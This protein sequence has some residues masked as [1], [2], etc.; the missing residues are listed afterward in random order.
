Q[1]RCSF[2]RVPGTDHS[3][4]RAAVLE[5]SGLR[6]HLMRFGL[7]PKLLVPKFLVPKFLGS[8]WR[9]RTPEIATAQVPALSVGFARAW[10]CP[11]GSIASYTRSRRSAVRHA[12]PGRSGRRCPET[13]QPPRPVG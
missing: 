7:V 12:A 3:K 8:A 2:R 9:P 13:T 4:P 1:P 10:P 11:D 5:P 6:P